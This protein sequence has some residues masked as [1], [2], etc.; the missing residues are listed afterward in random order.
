ML[1][2][3]NDNFLQIEK[4]QLEKIKFYIQNS[5]SK[6]TQRSY[7]SDWKHFSEWC[8]KHHRSFLPADVE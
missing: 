4:E 3:M 2:P 7:S 5:K 8:K 1:V 6:N